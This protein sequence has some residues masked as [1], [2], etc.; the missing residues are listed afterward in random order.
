MIY[1]III[2]GITILSFIF[3]LLNKKYAKM[4]PNILKVFALLFF[5]VFFVRLGLTDV[6]TN[7]VA[8][9]TTIMSPAMV[10]VISILRWSSLVGVLV[11]TITPFFDVKTLKNISSFFLPIVVILNIIFFK[12]HIIAFEGASFSFTSLRTIQFAVE[13]VLMATLSAFYLYKK[14]KEKDFENIKEQVKYFFIILPLIFIAIIPLDFIKNVFGIIGGEAEDFTLIHRITFYITFLA[15]ALLFV[16]FR[17]KSY[18]IQRSAL[19]LMSLACVINYLYTYDI[20]HLTFNN[21]PLHLCN[22]AVFLIFIAFTFKIKSVFYFNYIVNVIGGIIA[23]T[24]PNTSGQITTVANMHFWYN[25]IYIV[26]LP[27]LAR[28]FGHYTRPTL[29]LM[30][31]AILIFSIYFVSMMFMNA[32][33][34]SFSSVDYFFLYGDNITSKIKFADP[35]RLN[36]IWS[37]VVNDGLW[38]IFWLYD[39]LV[40]IG[41]IFLMFMIWYLYSIIY[42]V[43][44]HYTELAT[45]RKIDILEM[46]KF[47]KELNGRPM[48]SPINEKGINMIK[49]SHFSKVYGHSK[50]K[51]VNDFNL[52][53]HKGEVFGFLGHNGAGKSTLIKSMVGIQSIT[54]G[55]I[56][57]CGY[58]ISKQP[59]QA[60]R[61]IGYVSDNHA[62]YENLTG[63]EYINYVADLYMVNKQD[64]TER[65]NK[66][67]EMFALTHAIDNQIKT[68]S[69]GMKQKL[70][71]IAALIHNPKVWILDE[72]LTGLDPSSA[73]QIKECMREHANNGNIVFFSSH[74]IEVVEKIC[75]KIAIIKQG[76]LQGVFDLKKL[77][78]DGIDL[79]QLYLQYV[80]MDNIE[81][82]KEKK[83]KK[84][85]KKS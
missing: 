26:F 74:I 68:Y 83:N 23:I 82:P 14:I 75:D 43:E 3:I 1:A 71:V 65:L 10:V 60:K 36:Y 46:R 53:I 47:K 17:K 30:R 54:E 38:Q 62:V 44:D 19:L 66:Y 78:E 57:I 40:Y 79:E 85:V 45:L 13:I 49:I 61:H 50:I 69:H 6:I 22:T 51:S 72:P 8:R 12:Q 37:F 20:T 58:D 35:I 15:P 24:L 28:L 27:I 31:G 4:S 2:L 77:K 33:V 25:H 80:D 70:I 64:R 63:R 76:R 7:V 29:K 84:K 48:S 42:K 5:A 34:N 39:I 21:L 81:K 52:E 16:G 41:Y 59:L 9:E 55:T 73:F 18:V 11:T 56:E 32:W 67:T